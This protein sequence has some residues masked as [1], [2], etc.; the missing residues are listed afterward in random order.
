MSWPDRLIGI[1]LGIVIGVGAVILFVFFGA[2]STIDNA[3][4]DKGGGGNPP[5][6]EAPQ[7]PGRSR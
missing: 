6:I 2:E 1:T 4:L 5:A 3:S 7:Q